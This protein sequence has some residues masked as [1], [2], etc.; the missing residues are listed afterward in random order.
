[1]SYL[2]TRLPTLAVAGCYYLRLRSVEN[3]SSD[4][5]SRLGRKLVYGGD[6]YLIAELTKGSR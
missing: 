1:M 3:P 4:L 6:G 5:N 2:F